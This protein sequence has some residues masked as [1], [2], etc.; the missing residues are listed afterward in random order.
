MARKKKRNTFSAVTQVKALARAVVGT[1][2]AAKVLKDKKKRAA[3]KHSKHKP[4]LGTLLASD[5]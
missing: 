1:P 3:G 4:T 5:E 2:P